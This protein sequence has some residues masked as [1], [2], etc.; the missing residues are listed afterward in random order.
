[1][2]DRSPQQNQFS[3]LPSTSGYSTLPYGQSS[4]SSTDALYDNLASLVRVCLCGVIFILSFDRVL[5]SIIKGD[6]FHLFLEWM[7]L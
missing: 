1:M 7:N 3:T 2:N 6:L 4:Q 5:V